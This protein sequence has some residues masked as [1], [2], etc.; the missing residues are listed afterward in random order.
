MNIYS[1]SCRRRISR[2]SLSFALCCCLALTILCVSPRPAFANAN[3]PLLLSEATSTRAVALDSATWQR[4]P[5]SLTQT[6]PMFAGQ[7]TRIVLFVMNLQS[8]D[9]ASIVTADAEDAQRRRYDL[10][11]EYVGAVPGYEW[12]S[13]IVVKLADGMSD[14][15]DVLVQI[16]VR[17]VAS[18]R[19]R[20][21]IGRIGG[22][23]P[24]DAGSVPT[25]APYPAPTPTA[26]PTPTPKPDSVST[27]DAVRFLEQSTFGPTSASVQRV[28]AIGFRNF[29]DEQLAAAPTAY[30][31]LQPFPSDS[32]VGCPT[33][34]DQY[35]FRDNYTMY[36]LQVRFFQNALSGQDQLR[37]RV[38][39]ALSQILVVSGVDVQQPSSMAPFQQ[40]L[41]Q[42]PEKNFRQLMHDVT[43][44]PAMGRYL[45]MVN[46]D[47]PN[48]TT[49]IE[50][51][52]N[53]AR[54]L[55][56]LF[57]IGVNKLNQDGTPMLNAEGRFIPTYDQETVEG[58]AHVF[59]GWTFA[60][61]PPSTTITRRNPQYY[62]APMVVYASNHDAS[63][64]ELLDGVALPA[65]QTAE[66]DLSDAL[67]N[68]FNHPN[69]APFISK[70]LIQHLVTSNP[71]PAY[72]GRVA[73]VFND[74]GAGV[75]G[76]LKAGVRAIL[77]DAEARGDAKTDAAYGR[78]REPVQFVLNVLRS[79]NATSDGYGLLDQTR[80]MGQN[81]F[82]SPSVFNFYPP[83]YQ[84]PGTQVLGPQF[85]IQTTATALAR[86]NFVNTIV[87][88]RIAPPTG[89]P[90]GATGASINLTAWE[91]LASDPA[92]LVD[93]LD[94]VLMHNSMSPQTRAVVTQAVTSTP[95]TNPKLRAQTAIYL[96]ATS[97]QYQVQR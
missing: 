63:A 13:A 45:D 12:M 11:V 58:F 83:N 55:L 71:S 32:N 79:L 85:G 76:D 47:K 68:I 82:N 37:Q 93:E 31:N 21:G 57:T 34:S 24:D 51:N 7:R 4:E 9:T 52:E 95:A 40:L 80:G 19:V 29:I 91:A 69:V 53:Y 86:M 14:L 94:K 56:Q 75:R 36:P 78:L 74:N 88:S 5:F 33:G 65:G 61:I 59:T 25:P 70:Q 67:D 62:L 84:I 64:K 77:L 42:W 89:S 87:F 96:V 6:V 16:K 66:K 60:P 1:S 23:L 28:Q 26:S 15:G 41:L 49:G 92:K 73:A 72:V 22:G 27:P 35:C 10:T 20:I 38:A 30:P 2:S 8:G 81:V 44:N 54:E 46:N 3:A 48:P 50:P 90:A 43:L 17:G 97:S 39:F 18:N